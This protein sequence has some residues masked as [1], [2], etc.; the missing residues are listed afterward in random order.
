M[1]Q[2]KVKALLCQRCGLPK[3]HVRFNEGTR[4]WICPCEDR[5]GTIKKLSLHTECG[6]EKHVCNVALAGRAACGPEF[7]ICWPDPA[8]PGKLKWFTIAKC[9][10]PNIPQQTPPVLPGGEP[11]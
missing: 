4:I 2:T 8:R 5:S 10:C 6:S 1:S 7:E 3:F 9:H 11:T